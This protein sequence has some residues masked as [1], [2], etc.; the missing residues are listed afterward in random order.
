[1]AAWE[2]GSRRILICSIG[3]FL[4]LF[5]WLGLEP[6]ASVPLRGFLRGIDPG[7]TLRRAAFCGGTV[8][9]EGLGL[10]ARGLFLDECVVYWSGSILDPSVDSVLVL[11]GSWVPGPG[12]GGPASSGGGSVLP[13][14]RF[15]DLMLLDS[16]DSSLACGSVFEDSLGRHVSITMQGSWGTLAGSL[17]LQDGRDSACI[18][19]FE[20]SRVPGGRIRL[21]ELLSG[22]TVQG[23][24]TAVMDDHLEASGVISSINGDRAG[25]SFLIDDGGGS[26]SV[27]LTSRLEDLREV[28]V[29]GAREL[30][31]GSYVDLVP[32]G[33]L[34]LEVHESDTVGIS[35]NARLDSIRIHCPGLSADTVSSTAGMTLEG[36]FCPGTA[37]V[38]VD[39]GTFRIGSLPVEF[40][41]RGRF[42]GDPW[43]ELELWNDSV[44]GGD[45]AASVPSEL[46][47]PLEGLEMSGRGAFYAR[48]VL[49]WGCPD[50]SD[51]SA[52]V[53]ASGLRV[54]RSPVHVGQ[55]RHGGSCLMR[56]SWGGRRTVYLDTLLNEDF[57]VF[58]SLPPSFEGL[59]RCA[60]DATFRTHEGF[61]EY[62]VRNSIIA[63]METGRFVRGGSTISMQ[64]AR[65]LF[66]GREKTLAR[67]VQEVFLTWRLEAYLSKD[68]IMEIYANIVELGP[69]VFGFGEAARYYFGRELGDLSTRQMAYL[70]SILPGP[71]LYY[72]FFSRRSVPGYWEDYLDRLIRISRDRG[73]VDP[74]SARAA[75]ADSITFPAAEGAF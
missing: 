9:V 6:L 74:D 44:D 35:V 37:A 24:M 27:I 18:T 8:V 42:F 47:G 54:D 17:L 21:P 60:E 64:L 34:V 43:L 49:D 57:I 38:T 40:R 67:K 56:D 2:C 19:W 48:L 46:L 45:L 59:L 70:V 16:G 7:A 50:S 58:D 13:P 71:R 14:C 31:P 30:I 29:S 65:N 72:G 28:I 33:T 23:R 66:L 3:L 22:I 53:D 52:S 4:V 12:A 63:N 39:S 68:R 61:C 55:L 15:A 73:W 5:T 36:R 25:V 1:V 51:F 10:P 69:G 20:L 75:L 62:H 32:S 26:T 41:M 11:G